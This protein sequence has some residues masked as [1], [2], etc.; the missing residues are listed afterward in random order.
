MATKKRIILL[1]SLIV[2]VIISIIT[3]TITS[4]SDNNNYQ[5]VI[6]R[7]NNKET[8]VLLITNKDNEL[9]DIMNYYKD[10]YSVEYTSLDYNNKKEYNEILKKL[11]Y[12]GSLD[13]DS[14]LKLYKNGEEI[15]G[16]EGIFSENDIKILLINNGLI[17]KE[18]KE[19][20][21]LSLSNI[22]VNNSYNVLYINKDN[23]DL[24]E[25][26]K[27]LVKNKIK[28]AVVFHGSYDES[29]LAM[30][31]DEEYNTFEKDV[32]PILIKMKKNQIMYS[33]T[34]I[35]LKDLVNKSK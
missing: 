3:V 1:I 24:Y 5:E 19:I 23:K 13:N 6:D 4:N 20:D 32:L 12:D 9:L 17:D 10:V 14:L 30:M 28:S 21:S 35:K 15:A 31:L 22:D 7:I 11:S 33:T 25:Y 2:I 8:F 18:Y 27:L 16:I 26:R 34:N 29:G